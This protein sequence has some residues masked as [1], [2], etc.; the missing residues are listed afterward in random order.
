M[1]LEL[2]ATPEEVM[3]SVE[4]L[5]QLGQEQQVPGEILFGLSLAL[6]ECGTNIVNY[7]LQRDACQ[8]FFVT[9]EYTGSAFVV[10]LRD[11]GPE[12]DPT[13][14]PLREKKEFGDDQPHG[15]WGIMLARGHTDEM[16]YVREGGENVLRLIKRF[17][18]LTGES[19]LSRNTIQGGR[20]TMK[21]EI[22]IQENI[23]SKLPGVITVRLAGSLDT[24]TS[25]E[26]ERELSTVL[27]GPVKGL[28]FDMAQL[29]F[30]SSAGLRVISIVR[31]KLVEKGGMTAVINM[32]P[33]I[34]EV[35]EIIRALPGMDIFKNEAE[36]D[37][38]ITARQ[39]RHV[40]GG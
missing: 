27:A 37:E 35:F 9:L 23:G 8:T 13:Q 24:A 3:R 17:D 25:P 38:Y 2:H 7:A 19:L 11:C 16:L 30:I 36:F 33:Q 10:E 31:K 34:R 12:F 20:I 6:E 40:E 28:V 26:L 1:K 4:A 18:L 21:L 39:R 14:V 15:G 32:Q 29:K 5:Q 22:Q